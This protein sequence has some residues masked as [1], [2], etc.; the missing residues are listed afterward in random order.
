MEGEDEI[1]GEE[2]GNHQG[3]K[4]LT[5]EKKKSGGLTSEEA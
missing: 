3:G 4:G 1:G 5:I 2:L